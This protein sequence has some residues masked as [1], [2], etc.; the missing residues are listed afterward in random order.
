MIVCW[1]MGIT[2]HVH[3]VDTIREIVNLALLGGHIGRP[4]AGLCP[5]RGHSNVQGD[6]TMGV[7]ERPAA[8]LLDALERE[9]GLPMP[10]AEGLDSVAAVRAMASGTASVFV[11]L[12]GNLARASPDTTVAETAFRDLAL[13]VG[14]ATTLNRTHVLSEG[15]TVL[16]PT[17]GRSDVDMGPMGRR[18]VTVEDSMGLVH[19]STG[20]LRPPSDQVR[21]EVSILAALGT[22]LFTH[23]H[24]VTWSRIGLDYDVVRDHISRVIPGFED[25]STRIL[26]GA[27]FELPHPPRDE[28]RFDTPTGRAQF[29]VTAI[30]PVAADA[31]LLQTMRSHDQFNTSVYSTNDRYRSI[32]G[33]RD[34]LFISDTDLRRLGLAAGDR[35]DIVTDMSGPERRLRNHRLVEYP[36]PA[37]SVAAYFPEAN[38][39]VPLEH[40]GSIVST[41]GY[42]S[43]PVRLERAGATTPVASTLRVGSSDHG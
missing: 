11:G 8:E 20:V 10:R 5:V 19:G 2:H 34:V 17:L 15:L 13:N 26:D 29:A 37:G 23:K 27:G 36:T 16:L 38:V 3:A 33:E 7:F 43:V 39:L 41:P 25:F 32:S 4:G 21:S 30:R 18:T 40:H 42:K 9:F 24:A 31:L 28:R 35:V 12:G 1:A 6:R 14:I 22:R